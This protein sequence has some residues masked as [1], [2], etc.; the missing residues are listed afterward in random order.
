MLDAL[1]GRL[2]GR[3]MP[4]RQADLVLIPATERALHAV[5]HR[6]RQMVAKRALL[7]AGA[8]A[9]PILGVDIAVD[10][11]LLSRLIEDINAEFGLTPQQIDKLQPKLK[12][13]TYSTIVGLGSTLI[14]RAVTRE[15]MLK[16]LTR[17]GVKVLS[18][19]ATRLVPIA[20]QMVSAAIG[21]SAFRAIGNRH[22]EA[23]VKVAEE[24]LKMQSSIE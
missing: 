4:S 11:H 15:L 17:S 3:K 10:I 22:I 20:G 2:P 24:M 6:C 1:R 5:R 12:V 14:G 16:I 18:K 8:S 7:S 21:F 19:N 13:A 23:C 9:L